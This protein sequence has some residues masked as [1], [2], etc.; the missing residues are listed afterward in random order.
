[1]VWSAS[2]AVEALLKGA[3]YGGM[4]FKLRWV[5]AAPST[6]LHAQSFPGSPELVQYF[7]TMTRCHSPLGRQYTLDWT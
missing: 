7:V 6:D 4:N 5:S 3:E 2:G 1:M